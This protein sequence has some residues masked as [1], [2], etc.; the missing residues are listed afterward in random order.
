M[1]IS[2]KIALGFFAAVFAVTS[3]GASAQAACTSY[4]F[5]AGLYK[6]FMKAAGVK[7]VQK[8]M[9]ENGFTIATTGAGSAGY[10]TETYG[11]KTMMAVKAFQMAKS[12]SP[13]SGFFGSLSRA[14]AV[15]HQTAN[16]AGGPGP[17][18]PPVVTGPVSAA[19]ATTN[20]SAGYIVAGQATADLAHFTFTGT[21]TVNTVK[22]LRT[23]ISANT[24]LSNVYL[25]EGGVRLT[26]AATVN[27]L[28]EITFNNVNLMVSGSKTVS[29][30]ADVATGTSGQTVGVT[31]TGYTLT[32]AAAMTTVSVAGNTMSVSGAN[33]IMAG[34]TVG[35]NTAVNGATVNPGTTGYVL[36]SAPVQVATRSVMLKSAAFRY[37]GSATTDALANVKLFSNGVQIATASGINAM[38]YVVFDMMSAPVT[39][40][41]GS[42]TLEVRA[43]IVKGS[44]RTVSLSLQNVAD[45]MV[46]DSQL[47]V[48]VAATG[49]PT[50]QATINVNAGSLSVSIDPTFSTMTNVTGGATNTAVAK[51]KVRAYGED[52]KV[53]RL[54]VT[55]ILTGAA[56]N[57]LNNLAVYFNGAQVGSS[58][59]L[60][61]GL[62]TGTTQVQL[63]SS[64]IIPA[65]VDSTIEIRA[66]LQSAANVNYTT[67]TVKANIAMVAGQ[68]QGMNSLT[69]TASGTGTANALTIQTGALAVSS[70][71]AY[72]GPVVA[73][74]SP[75]QKIGSFILQNNSSSESV[76]VTNLAVAFTGATTVAL[77][78]LANLKTSE[79]SGSGATPV[80]P[81]TSNS[82]SVDFTVAP[83]STK[84]IDIF[85]DVNAAV[86]ADVAVVSL[87]P[88]AIGSASNVNV[89][90]GA[91]ATGQT[92][93]INVAT[94]T[95]TLAVSPN[96]VTSTSSVSQY[97]AAGA[98][99][100]ADATQ[101]TY[102]FKSTNGT[103]A[104]TKL[105]FTGITAGIT[106]VKVGSVSASVSGGVAY[107]QGLNIAVPNAGAGA[108]VNVLLSYAP[109]VVGGGVASQTAL[110]EKVEL[111]EVEY[112]AGSVTTTLTTLA[113]AANLVSS[114]MQLVGS[115]P[116][117]VAIAAVSGASTA[118]T[119]GNKQ[120]NV[121][122]GADAK[123]DILLMGFKAN[124]TATPGI[125]VTAGPG[126]L[127]ENGSIVAGAT[128]TMT[129]TLAT[130]SFGA[131]GYQ[132]T[133]G[134]AKTFTVEFPVT[135]TP[136]NSGESLSASMS[137]AVSALTF[138]DIAG[139]GSTTLGT[140]ATDYTKIVGYPTSSVTIMSN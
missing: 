65:N 13:A 80:M 49:I 91:A 36:F 53:M 55:P 51:F 103:A 139:N 132:I 114:T 59:N 46:T 79:T 40:N 110:T 72:V 54:D 42:T 129:S 32:G 2:K 29:V 61:A 107:L 127:K 6:P 9:N 89:T 16:C 43:D 86:A 94:L 117:G 98:T 88:T 47:G 37:I 85:A 33:N 75:N 34:V 18:N 84:T 128:V 41:T 44:N 1:S 81:Q 73:P 102:N 101:I 67:G 82:F 5:G 62:Q 87:L 125:A 118:V 108:N 122:V 105:K 63:G 76:R 68:V 64:M 135:V 109:V 30:K 19:L 14:A 77:T 52:M 3:V 95:N 99:G 21:G 17:V 35:T 113:N 58:F 131:A 111:T 130:V 74:N 71:P 93:T 26:D 11:T 116:T 8:F 104:I 57:G 23:G 83:G 123:G 48:N 10:E 97:V 20:P 137:T 12:V 136:G 27:T 120:M 39:L 140:G 90:P 22:F 112:V 25:Y 133:A 134:T 121:T 15:N 126:V 69:T 78:N 138:K 96:I 70:N 124:L 106:T 119:G 50:T 28:G 45:L 38:N 100:A 31:L 115:K 24:T 66:D 56:N 60:G 92:V 4:T 7:E